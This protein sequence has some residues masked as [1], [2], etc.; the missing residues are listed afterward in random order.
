MRCWIA[1]LFVASCVLPAEAFVALTPDV[2]DKRP[3]SG[4]LLSIQ[5]ALKEAKTEAEMKTLGKQITGGDT[6]IPGK[7]S[8]VAY[9]DQ[10]G[11]LWY[12]RTRTRVTKA[13]SVPLIELAWD[14][15][16]VTINQ[17]DPNPST[18]TGIN[19]P[20]TVGYP[21]SGYNPYWPGVTPYP[22]YPISL[23][24][25]FPTFPALQ[26]TVGSLPGVQLNANF[27]PLFGLPWANQNQ[28][29]M[30]QIQPWNAFQPSMVPQ[31]IN[32]WQLNQMAWPQPMFNPLLAPQQQPWLN[33]PAM[34]N[35]Q[36][37]QPGSNPSFP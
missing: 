23:T 19:F 10:D 6:W 37:F 26:P 34:F 33:R 22:T 16:F 20:I 29:W 9:R 4:G 2:P 1:V 24:P 31:Q 18:F 28:P 14:G 30:N 8:R 35:P 15:R 12:L 5:R 13:S 21:I 3:L 27:N 11:N 36:Q 25:S 17:F 7:N 32:P